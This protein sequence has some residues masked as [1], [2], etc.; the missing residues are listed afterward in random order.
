MESHTKSEPFMLDTFQPFGENVGEHAVGLQVLQVDVVG[1]NSLSNKVVAGGDMFGACVVDRLLA[2]CQSALVVTV[3]SDGCS[4]WD[5][6]VLL[7]LPEP[8]SFF[9]GF[10]C[11]SVLCFG[12]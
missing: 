10:C 2:E 6:E 9:D 7:Q 4:C 11:R 5:Q 3:E 12:G 1:V 8:D